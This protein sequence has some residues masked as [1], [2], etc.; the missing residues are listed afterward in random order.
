MQ[1][2]IG[3]QIIENH[4]TWQLLTDH[5][6]LR[7]S[8]RH[9]A[10]VFLGKS[11]RTAPGANLLRVVIVD[12]GSPL[13]VKMRTPARLAVIAKRVVITL[14]ALA[15]RMVITNPALTVSFVVT[16]AAV[17]GIRIVVSAHAMSGVA[18]AL[19]ILPALMLL[20]TAGRCRLIS[21]CRTTRQ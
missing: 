19:A 15:V 7:M 4:V 9:A 17:I 3:R 6:P 2:D 8:G 16:C 21:Q 18:F 14:P 1:E 20:A 13:I 12:P 11:W 10:I 5:P